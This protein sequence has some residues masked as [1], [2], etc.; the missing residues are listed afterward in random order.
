MNTQAMALPKPLRQFYRT[1]RTNLPHL[2]KPQAKTL[3]LWSDAILHTGTCGLTTVATYAALLLR[4]PQN[5]LRQRLREFYKDAAH[6]SGAQ[7]RERDITPCFAA[8][9][10]WIV[11]LGT[12]PHKRLALALDAT[13]LKQRFTVLSISVLYQHRA[14]PVA[15]KVIPANQPGSWQPYWEALLEALRPAIPKD[16]TVLVCADRGLYAKWLFE[17]IVSLGWHPFLRINAQGWYRQAGQTT[18]QRLASVVTQAGASWWGQVVCFKEN[19]LACTLLA[20]W[21]AGQSEAWLIVTDLPPERARARWYGMRAW[22]E[23]GFADLKRRGWQWHKTQMVD[24]ARAARVWLAL[25]VAT[26]WVVGVGSEVAQRRA[27]CGLGRCVGELFSFGSV[28]DVGSS[29][30]WGVVCVRGFSGWG[31]VG[32]AFAACVRW[33]VVGGCL[34]CAPPCGSGRVRVVLVVYWGVVSGLWVFLGV[35]YGR[36]WGLVLVV[37]VFI[38]A[39]IDF[40]CIFEG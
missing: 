35:V 6:K 11:R 36:E 25:A 3:A 28:A 20:S 10:R 22:I 29:G 31:L 19:P 18:Y 37:V 40:L 32:G 21:E 38:G 8:L 13:T 7:R 34:G 27:A 15:W 33:G 9:L 16:W 23:S 2:T 4:Q 12:P 17:R 14:I 26:L 24:G 5:T 1:I 39:R 30:A